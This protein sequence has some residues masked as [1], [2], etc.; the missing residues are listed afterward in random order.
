MSDD[1]DKLAQLSTDLLPLDLDEESARRI[2]HR[3]RESVGRGPSPTR[4]IE[5]IAV[6]LFEI[7]FFAWVL[8]KVMEVLR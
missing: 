5:P 7:S 2:A 8:A 3:A 4:F 1:A 6:A